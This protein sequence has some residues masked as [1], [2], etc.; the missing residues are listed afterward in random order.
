MYISRRERE[1]HTKRVYLIG[2]DYIREIICSVYRLSLSLCASGQL[3]RGRTRASACMRSPE[4]SL[5]RVF[6]ARTSRKSSVRVFVDALLIGGFFFNKRRGKFN[7]R[8]YS[9]GE[10]GGKFNIRGIIL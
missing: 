7:K 1:R 9:T 6:G 10:R 2:R 3:T 8:G 4:L 5:A